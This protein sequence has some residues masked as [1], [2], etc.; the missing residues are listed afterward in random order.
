MKLKS[1]LGLLGAFTAYRFYKLYELGENVIY[2]PFSVK[3]IRGKTINDFIVQVTMEI[4]N[5]TKTTLSMRGIDGKLYIK[6]SVLG[7]YSS[8]PFKIKGGISRFPINFKI[9]PTTTGVALITMIITKKI[10]VFSVKLTK[11]LPFF[12]LTED[13]DINPALVDTKSNV[14]VK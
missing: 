1:V 4:M 14:I 8:P 13:F 2:K 12:S 3:F 7:Y 10:P 9:D 6:D 5:P 11:K